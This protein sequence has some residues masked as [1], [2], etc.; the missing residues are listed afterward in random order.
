[1][2]L[3]NTR[4]ELAQ[5]LEEVMSHAYEQLEERQRLEAET[6]LL[7]TYLVEAHRLRAADH[8]RTLQV[9]RETFVPG[10]LGRRIEPQIHETEDERFFNIE[11]GRRDDQS[12]L[13]V[14]ASNPRF[15][16]IHSTA[17]SN[18]VDPIIQKLV[19][20][21][22]EY[23][24]VWLPMQLLSRIAE[25]GSLRG[26][27]L[28]Y[29]RRPVPDVD[30]EAPDAPV[31]FLKIQL[32]GNR[33]KDVLRI[34]QQQD[35]F[36]DATTLSKVK[37][38]YYLDHDDDIFCLADIKYDGKVTG[39]GTSYQSY[40]TLVTN[41]Y[42]DYARRIEEYEQ[43][44][45]VKFIR[46]QRRA[47]IEDQSFFSIQGEPLNIRFTQ[48]LPNI[49]AFCEK[50]FSGSYP[51]RLMGVPIKTGRQNF[52]VNAIDLHVGKRIAVEISPEFMR[53][54]L[55]PGGCGNSL[56]RLYTNLQHH[57]NSQV[58]A[59]DGSEQLTFQP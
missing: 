2:P 33:A 19:N 45:T 41:L 55:S 52:R 46:D 8:D 3:P 57:Y 11:F 26:L 59:V 36:P 54:Y 30:F 16:L 18:D 22:N 38:K 28:D 29:D 56:A 49:E 40:I 15:W 24:H 37:V 14:D 13:Y 10:V 12:V 20:N 39:R 7:K 4:R 50:V 53:V 48:S 31:Q 35:A 1:M 34:L 51:F 21:T 58:E 43:R 47:D 9:I 5:Y 32:W 44:F 6:S 23:D 25:F 17:K 42:R 27:G